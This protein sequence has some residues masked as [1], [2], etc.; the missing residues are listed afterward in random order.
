MSDDPCR[1]LTRT[2]HDGARLQGCE[3]GGHLTGWWPAGASGSRL[4]LSPASTCG[5]GLAIRGG[6]PV[7]FPQF[8]LLGPLP[9]HGLARDHAWTLLDTPPGPEAALAFTTTVGERAQWP[10]RAALTVSAVA[11]GARL[12]VRLDVA[13]AGGTPLSFTAALHTYLHVTST[14]AARVE[15]LPGGRLGT[16]GPFDRM[17]HDVP[18]PLTLRDDGQPPLLIDAEGF[19]D[20]VAWNPGPGHGLPDVREGDETAFVCLEPASLCPVHLAPGDVWWSTLTLTTGTP[21]TAQTPHAE[22]P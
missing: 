10:H 15:G 7:V 13:N 6:I 18:G 9:K 21:A 4:W 20:W 22:A 16:V 19:T 17:F 8:G 12:T 3:H 1:T 5:P 11:R 2:S 14:D